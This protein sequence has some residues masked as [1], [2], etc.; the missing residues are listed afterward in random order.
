MTEP[1]NFLEDNIIS[2]ITMEKDFK[3]KVKTFGFTGRPLNRG[4]ITKT[5]LKYLKTH[6]LAP[7]PQGKVYYKNKVVDRTKLVDKRSKTGK[8][9]PTVLKELGVK[10]SPLRT[11][12]S[13]KTQVIDNAD[14]GSSKY[15]LK[16]IA[17]SFLSREGKNILSVE[18]SKL[19]REAAKKYNSNTSNYILTFNGTTWKTYMKKD[20]AG[21]LY[22]TTEQVPF[23]LN[24]SG[25][26]LK[27]VNKHFEE[28]WN[29]W[30]ENNNISGSL[31]DTVI[32]DIEL[33]VISTQQNVGSTGGHYST[34]TIDG[35]KIRDFESKG[36]N[37][38][39]FWVIEDWIKEKYNRKYLTP[40]FCNIIRKKFGLEKDSKIS[41]E[42]CVK[43]CKEL[44][45]KFIYIINRYDRDFTK[46]IDSKRYDRVLFIM[47]EH[48]YLFEG[49]YTSKYCPLCKTTYKLTHDPKSCLK[50]VCYMTEDKRLVLPKK[51]LSKK[52]SNQKFV[53]HYDIETHTDNSAHEHVPYIV[54]Y[55][56][57]DFKKKSWVYGTFE[58]DHCMD[59]FYDYVRH[60]PKI[61]Y[62]NAY[63]GNRFD[64][65]YLSKLAIND[66]DNLKSKI[67]INAGSILKLTIPKLIESKTIEDK[68][69]KK[70]YTVFPELITCDLCR[71]LDGKLKDQLEDNNCQVSK[72]DIDH[73]ISVRWE[74][75]D[76]N[77]RREVREYLEC[78]VM[79]LREL[80][81]K[82]D[83]ESFEEHGTNLC[84]YLTGSQLCYDLWRTKYL[85]DEVVELPNAEDDV[86]M[87]KSIYGGRCYP[88]KKSFISKSYE[89]IIN[90]K[91]KY[92]DVKD[93]LV[94]ADICS[95]Y[96]YVMTF[97]Y[98]TGHHIKTKEYI[99]GK[100]GIYKVKYTTN[101]KL[102]IAPIPRRTKKGLVWDLEDG[103]G[104]YTSVDIERAKTVGYEFQ[105]FEGIYWEETAPIYK[106]YMETFYKKKEEATKGTPGYSTAK[107]NL[108]ALY[109]K[110][111]QRPIYT[112]QKIVRNRHQLLDLMVKNRLTDIQEISLTNW[113]ISFEPIIIEDTDKKVNKP[114]HEGAFILAYS[115]NVMWDNFVASGG[116]YDM[117]K[118]F[119][120]TDTD[121]IQL[122]IDSCKNIK[123]GENM[124]DMS[125]D[126]G[127]G[128]K[129]IKAIWVQPKLYFL[130]SIDQN[131]EIHRHYR[132]AGVPQEQL[133][134]GVYE[135]LLSGKI[136][137]F[138]P[139]FQI[140]KNLFSVKNRRHNNGIIE[141]TD[142]KLFS[143]YHYNN[144]D[145]DKDG[146][147]VLEKILGTE[148]WKG[149]NFINNNISY[150]HGYEF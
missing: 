146:N 56:H 141:N 21:N 12:L 127:D 93:Y 31:F 34:Q 36:K 68:E 69:T 81:E 6:P 116:L 55:T 150:P 118:L 85:G 39:F 16:D 101:K 72:G 95:L 40:K 138:S 106:D 42:N 128:C 13:K 100:M 7:L 139:E 50:R 4:R 5:Y 97:Q 143:L 9:K 133:D 98:P 60:C 91:I 71:H 27:L 144:T 25:K 136:R 75:T 109:G 92:N 30:I 32:E 3:K 11:Q 88:N 102:L 103:E 87:R 26:K 135:D 29:A 114:T 63:N 59:V 47:N 37:N 46:E 20:Q 70:K 61:K 18:V 22:E 67:C 113:L 28:Y 58:G 10:L 2:N 35:I 122:H 44:F 64:H 120:Y 131:M 147:L 104:I 105:I 65:F 86:F 17:I 94:D 19:R 142:V 84:D 121:S 123:W 89:D 77:R 107:R 82:F 149:R 124:G 15:I 110:Q 52:E 57:Y 90:G 115:R 41:P 148:S 108:N 33:R 74:E 125:N 43:I 38:C 119:Y 49:E 126:L 80:Y 140:K 130:E 134:V 53:L 112:D 83:T 8:L 137:R 79:G 99:D 62:L 78:D 1:N 76:E 14:M 111:I 73:D 23:R 129:I 48:I 54:G 51:K 117:N 145:I 96:P 45:G 66:C 24:I 132:G